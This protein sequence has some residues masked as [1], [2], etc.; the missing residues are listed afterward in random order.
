SGLVK[1]S[2]G[3]VEFDGKDITN[4][5]ARQL[6]ELGIA[7]IPED[8]HKRGLLL[9]SDLAENS[10]LGVHY[11]P[12]VATAAGF[13]NSAAISGRVN[14]IIERFDVRPPNRALPAKSL[15]GGN[16]QKPIIGRAFELKPKLML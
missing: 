14:E 12:P 11:R 2:A 8:R 16:Q 9:H 15:S 7:H 10:I 1:A 4:H 6:K 5:T 3:T 13:M